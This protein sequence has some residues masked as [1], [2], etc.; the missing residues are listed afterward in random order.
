MVTSHRTGLLSFRALTLV[1]NYMLITEMI[2]LTSISRYAKCFEGQIC[3]FSQLY[4]C[5]PTR[6]LAHSGKRINV[7]WVNGAI[8]INRI[9]SWGP[10]RWG[11]L[12][13]VPEFTSGNWTQNTLLATH[14]PSWTLSQILSSHSGGLLIGWSVG[15]KGWLTRAWTE[16]G[17]FWLWDSAWL[18]LFWSPLKD[19]VRLRLLDV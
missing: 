6:C 3:L 14:F 1:C 18:F 16:S 12:P 4:L 8:A 5:C 10:E 7:Y 19:R 17:S 15:R 2:R 9:K 11:D 13:R